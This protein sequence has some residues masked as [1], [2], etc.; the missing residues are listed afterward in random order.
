MKFSEQLFR[1]MAIIAMVGVIAT[2]GGLEHHMFGFGRCVLQSGFF[3]LL[4]I[5]CHEQAEVAR[6]ATRRRRRKAGNK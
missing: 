5:F 6:R 3:M 4:A 1:F 2:I